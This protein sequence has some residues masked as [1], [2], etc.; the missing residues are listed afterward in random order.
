[1]TTTLRQQVETE[2]TS[3]ELDAW[4]TARKAERKANPD[5]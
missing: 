5:G 3:A 4:W 1:M 2:A